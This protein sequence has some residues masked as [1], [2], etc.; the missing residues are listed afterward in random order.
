MWE[1]QRPLHAR[2]SNS[3]R[4]EYRRIIGK[5]HP[6]VRSCSEIYEKA[7]K[8]DLDVL[9]ILKQVRIDSTASI[10]SDVLEN[11]ERVD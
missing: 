8:L 5:P 6:T 10:R 9:D 7:R 11:N 4:V 2:S 1:V 3:D